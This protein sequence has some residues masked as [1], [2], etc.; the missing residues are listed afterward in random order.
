M[1]SHTLGTLATACAEN[2]GHVHP[3]TSPRRSFQ[4]ARAGACMS[5]RRCYQGH[6]RNKILIGYLLLESWADS[7]HLCMAY[8]LRQKANKLPKIS[9][10]RPQTV[11]GKYMLGSVSKLTATEEAGWEEELATSGEDGGVVRDFFAGGVSTEVPASGCG[12]G[13]GVQHERSRPRSF[14]TQKQPHGQEGR[15]RGRV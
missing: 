8:G 15:L 1:F 3:H 11:S 2:V 14:R 10:R 9:L 12:I 4:N 13:A 7:R 5:Y 6:V